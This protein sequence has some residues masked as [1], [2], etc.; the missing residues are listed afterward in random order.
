MSKG[1]AGTHSTVIDAAR[2]LVALLEERGR[3]S[4]GVIEARVGSSGHT[5]KIHG[6]KGGV[7]LTVTAKGARQ[8]FHVY[9]IPLEELR[10]VLG[11]RR[12]SHFLVRE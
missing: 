10:L 12:L 8:E 1:R 3:V 11:D 6:L 4:R 5:I 2:H 7:R 9:G